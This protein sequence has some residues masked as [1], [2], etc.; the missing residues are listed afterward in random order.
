MFRRRT[1]SGSIYFEA[2][3]DGVGAYLDGGQSYTL[4]VPQPVP[5]KLF[6][7]VTAYDIETRSQVQTPQDKAV[8]TSLRDTFTPGPDG[9]VEIYFGPEPPAGPPARKQH[10]IQTS[11]ERGFFLYFRIYGPEIGAFDGSWRPGDMTPVEAPGK[12]HPAVDDGAL[13]GISTPEAGPPATPGGALSF[14]LGVPTAETAA[15][16][17]D[18]LDHHHAFDAYLSGLRAVSLT[19]ARRGFLEAGINDNTSSSSRG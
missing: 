7:S 10:W 15:A 16:I 18:Q 9:S 2:I 6:W 13:R 14:P 17:Y 4:T 12:M 3:R 11:P 5:A 1:G 8:L 19:A